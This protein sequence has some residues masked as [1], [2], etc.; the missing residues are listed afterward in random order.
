MFTVSFPHLQAHT[1][2]RPHV[3]YP[4]HHTPFLHTHRHTSTQGKSTFLGK[5]DSGTH[6]P[7][8]S[9]GYQLPPPQGGLSSAPTTHHSAGKSLQQSY[10]LLSFHHGSFPSLFWLKY[11]ISFPNLMKTPTQ[12]FNIVCS[13]IHLGEKCRAFSVDSS[14]LWAIYFGSFSDSFCKLLCSF[15]WV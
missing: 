9:P 11:N 12:M 2:H 1:T 8:P 5:A 4:S 7:A 3:T 6:L 14:N 13:Q 15:R 10:H